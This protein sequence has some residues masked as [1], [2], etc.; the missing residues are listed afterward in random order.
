MSDV[1]VGYMGYP[2]LKEYLESI[3]NHR[4][5]GW[6]RSKYR[7]WGNNHAIRMKEF[8]LATSTAFRTE[9]EPFVHV[10]LGKNITDASDRLW[11]S[12]SHQNHVRGYDA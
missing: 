11:E 6:F 9:H 3:W 8:R 5:H 7:H 2:T 4:P 1:K 10:A 12:F